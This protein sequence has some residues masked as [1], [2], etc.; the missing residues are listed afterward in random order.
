ME[1]GKANVVLWNTF[2]LICFVSF[3]FL[4]LDEIRKDQ[5]MAGD[6]RRHKKE[7]QYLW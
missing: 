3:R 1:K 5:G 6:L 7:D 4:L 2:I